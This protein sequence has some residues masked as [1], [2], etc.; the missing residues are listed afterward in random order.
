MACDQATC[1][2]KALIQRLQQ[3]VFELHNHRRPLVQL[4]SEYALVGT[5]LRLIDD[6]DR[7]AG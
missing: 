1:R 5:L 4:K 2:A 7:D 3:D 6:L